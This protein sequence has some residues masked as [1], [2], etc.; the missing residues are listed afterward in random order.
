MMFHQFKLL[1]G[2][3]EF[4][5]FLFVS[6]VAIMCQHL[7]R[8]LKTIEVWTTL[9]AFI[10]RIY[11]RPPLMTLCCLSSY[12]VLQ[13]FLM[14]LQPVQKSSFL[15]NGLMKCLS[16]NWTLFFFYLIVTCDLICDISVLIYKATFPNIAN[17]L[18][19]S[20]VLMSLLL[21]LCKI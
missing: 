8:P 15:L 3:Q 1:L 18:L 20:T 13:Q 21:C 19:L 6:A 16:A 14:R 12:W 4:C 10:I 9:L 5:H 11:N 7:L 2:V 17:E